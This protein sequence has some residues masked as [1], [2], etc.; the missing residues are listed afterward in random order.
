MPC[1]SYF[2]RLLLLV[3]VRVESCRLKV[4][5]RNRKQHLLGT[6]LLLPWLHEDLQVEGKRPNMFLIQEISRW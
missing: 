6:L 3:F 5:Y 1:L 4:Y 2:N